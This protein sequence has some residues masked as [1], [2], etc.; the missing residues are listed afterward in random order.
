MS[1]REETT[2]GF[3]EN[4]SETL[5]EYR[6]NTKVVQK[7][8]TDAEIENFEFSAY[9]LQQYEQQVGILE[10]SR[11]SKR[12]WPVGGRLYVLG[13]FL[14]KKRAERRASVSDDVAVT[15][16]HVSLTCPLS[17]TRMKVPCR[18]QSCKHLGCFDRSTYLQVNERKPTWRC[19]VC[20]MR[21]PLSS[22]V[23]DRLFAHILANVPGDCD[24][25]VLHKDGSWTPS[26]TPQRDNGATTSATPSSFTAHSSTPAW[27][28]SSSEQVWA[29]LQAVRDRSH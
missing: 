23:V 13:L 7:E 11:K 4:Q 3:V 17:R 10:K 29:V 8:R 26:S 5:E 20:G 16:L 1:S 21:A 15:G 27:G 25:V 24:S 9:G 18:A 22:L 2:T 6:V 19:P 14:V 12:E 28:S